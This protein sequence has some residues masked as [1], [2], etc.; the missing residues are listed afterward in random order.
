MVLH[1]V[2]GTTRKLSLDMFSVDQFF[3]GILKQGLVVCIR[4]HGAHGIQRIM[5]EQTSTVVSAPLHKIMT[6][7]HTTG[8]H[9]DTHTPP[10]LKKSG[11]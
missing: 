2:Q 1:P 5:A 7:T 8:T 11:S 3:P 4:E 9:A 10:T 6:H